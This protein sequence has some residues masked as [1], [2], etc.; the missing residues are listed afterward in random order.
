V[1]QLQQST[2]V[3]PWAAAGFTDLPPDQ[4]QQN[5]TA[6]DPWA[7]AGFSDYP[8]DST[9]QPPEHKE[10]FNEALLNT[11][12]ARL[13]KTAW[14]AFTLP[15]DV[16]YGPAPSSE[17]E[18]K[19]AADLAG[20]I[21]PVEGGMEQL[22]N[23]ARARGLGKPLESL[24]PGQQ[25]AAT[26]QSLGAPL[27]AGLA[28]D[29]P[30]VQNL[31]RKAEQVPFSGQ[32]ITKRAGETVQATGAKIGDISAQLGGTERATADV[33]AR[34]GIQDVIDANKQR[35]NDAYDAL[36]NEINPD[37]RFALPNTQRALQD[38]EQARSRA[39][40]DNP[41]QGLEQAWNLVDQGG[42]FN[43]VQRLRADLRDAGNP[44]APHPGFDAGDFRRVTGA[45]SAD[46]RNIVRNAS[47]DPDT[48]EGLFN[49]AERTAAQHIEENNFLGRLQNAQGEGAIS[50]I[51]NASKEKGG[52]LRLLGQLRRDMNPDDFSQIS[53]TLLNELGHNNATNA[54]SL[55]KFTTE[56]DRI[57]NGAKNVMFS[58]EHQQWINNI[59]SLGKHLK[60]ADKYV[61]NSNTSGALILW[62]IIR[63]V[64]E[65]AIGIGAGVIEPTAGLAAA[66]TFGAA[67]LGAKYLA[68]PASASAMSKWVNAYRA[69]TLGT[70]TPARAAQFM[71]ANRNLANTLSFGVQF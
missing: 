10:T 59:A 47:V 11:W 23:I 1:P 61:N 55:S 49:T 22:A 2:P 58:P 41:R 43:G 31:T 48:A 66:G 46:L 39:G 19:R 44:A 26:A 57:S 37:Q 6:A 52:N 71:A 60:N 24:S 9:P 20:M 14:S 68:R 38:V 7:A 33:T 36:R 18:I 53:G 5:A 69:V 29:T 8:P 27:P 45:V 16:V 56:W 40:W 21:L 63:A 35:I 65:G 25:A 51:L 67:H 64:A 54:F 17:E 15:H 50:S 13:A 32:A 4:P 3:D 70:P 34:R 12:P 28:S 42:G 62:D 30:W